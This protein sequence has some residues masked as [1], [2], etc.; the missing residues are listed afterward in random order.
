[1][2]DLRRTTTASSWPSID[3]PEQHPREGE[4][5]N[6]VFYVL[7]FLRDIGMGEWKGKLGAR[8]AVIAAATTAIDC[9]REAFR[10][11]AQ[12]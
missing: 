3:R 2:D 9:A 5:K 8:V 7:P 1:M 6:G 10:Q 4:D 11:G 12:K